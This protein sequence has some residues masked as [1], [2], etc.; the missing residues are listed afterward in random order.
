M[1]RVLSL[2]FAVALSL[3]S[4]A[5]A[6]DAADFIS[7]FSGE[8]LGSGQIL[9]GSENGLEF[10]C[11]LNG[12]PSRTQ[13]TFGMR[14]RCWMGSLSAPVHAQLR[15]H[16]AT[17]Q[18]YGEFMDGADGD[19]VDVVGRRAGGGFSMQLSRGPIQGRLSAEAVNADQMVVMLYY[20]SRLQNRDVPVVAMGFT[21][22]DAGMTLPDYLPE[23]LA[24]S[25]GAD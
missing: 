10:H 13:L 11:A 25:V 5:R 15:F 14:G 6:S 9:F 4:A 1:S 12:N 21:R 22:K 3:G 20:H 7:N 16:A 17:D 8:W 19:G 18:F 24:G 23:T 2:A